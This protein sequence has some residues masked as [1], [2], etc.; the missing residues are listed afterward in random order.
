MMQQYTLHD[1]W[2]S[3]KIYVNLNI[4]RKTVLDFDEA[5]ENARNAKLGDFI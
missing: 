4:I 1:D 5:I 3:F 2:N